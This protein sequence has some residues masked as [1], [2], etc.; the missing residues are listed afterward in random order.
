MRG[1]ACYSKCLPHCQLGVHKSVGHSYGLASF[2]QFA[3][4]P[5]QLADIHLIR[6]GCGRIFVSNSIWPALYTTCYK[7]NVD[8]NNMLTI[9]RRLLFNNF[10]VYKSTSCVSHISCDLMGTHRKNL[11][12]NWSRLLVMIMI[13]VNC[14]YI[15]LWQ[16]LCLITTV[17]LFCYSWVGKEIA[18]LRTEL[19]DE[20][21][22]RYDT[23]R[24]V[25]ME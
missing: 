22:S 20:F 19:G 24:Y 23:T 5:V 15:M 10:N 17:T 21:L 2:W 4:N 16:W 12:L 3:N 18:E 14:I 1:S 8:A 7:K 25:Y 13:H 11:A 9:L 6:C